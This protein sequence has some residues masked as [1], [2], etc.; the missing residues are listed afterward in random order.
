M[1]CSI[2]LLLGISLAWSSEPDFSGIAGIE[3][4]EQSEEVTDSESLPSRSRLDFACAVE[5]GR[6][7]EAYEK[8]QDDEG[9][10]A[11]W[12]KLSQE[13]SESLDSKEKVDDFTAYCRQISPITRDALTPVLDDLN[14]RRSLEFSHSLVELAD[15]WAVP[16]LDS[17]FPGH[18]D[19]KFWLHYKRGRELG[20]EI[21]SVKVSEQEHRFQKETSLEFTV[22]LEN[23]SSFRSRYPEY[24]NLGGIQVRTDSG[25]KA[26]ARVKVAFRSGQSIKLK[27]VEQVEFIWYRLLAAPITSSPVLPSL[28]VKAGEY[29]IPRDLPHSNFYFVL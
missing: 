17:H 26:A 7:T 28:Y 11:N 10:K 29:Y 25:V 21:G 24:Q 27:K 4:L 19:R 15:L 12:L 13:F 8:S 22:L 23:L 1:F 2:F 14:S 6:I 9:L 18:G 16:A 20:R 3:S 5:A